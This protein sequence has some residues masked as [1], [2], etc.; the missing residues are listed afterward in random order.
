M[1]TKHLLYIIFIFC[2]P[3]Q[4]AENSPFDLELTPDPTALETVSTKSNTQSNS[5]QS[6]VSS[7]IQNLNPDISFVADMLAGNR[8]A[9]TQKGDAIRRPVDLREVEIDGNGYISPYAKGAFVA[10]FSDG[11]ADIEEAYMNFFTLPG[12]VNL[13]LGKFRADI[14]TLNPTHQHAIP[15]VDQPLVFHHTFGLEG[16]K[17]AGA[18]ASVLVPNPF[19]QYLIASFSFG[20]NTFES[21]QYTS[22]YG[23]NTSSVLG[24]ARLGTSIDLSGSS[25]LTLN[26]STIIAPLVDLSITRIYIAEAL[27]RFSINPVDN[28][29]TFLNGYLWNRGNPNSTG[30][31]STNGFYSYLGW[32][33]SENWRVGGRFDYTNNPTFDGKERQYTGVL[34]YYPTET[35]FI[36]L[37]YATHELPETFLKT[38]STENRIWL[39]ID[40]SMGPHQQHTA[41]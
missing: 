25:Y 32:Q 19:N 3:V 31:F 37:Q 23:G 41:L 5:G 11:G 33:F 29:I 20:G 12:G 13:K 1:K 26:A 15:F 8:A 38:A 17:I 21:S 36:R 6:P 16:L 7:A 27:F 18:N 39:Q 28:A 30:Q 35:N 34:S 40:F 4:A 10:S 14:D 2:L 24:A 9:L 22:L